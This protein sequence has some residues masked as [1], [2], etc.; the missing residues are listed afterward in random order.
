MVDIYI[1]IIKNVNKEILKNEAVNVNF[2]KIEVVANSMRKNIF[3][4]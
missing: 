4:L 2:R 1:S 3:I